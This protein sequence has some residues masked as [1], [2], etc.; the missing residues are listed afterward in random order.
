MHEFLHSF[1][2]ISLLGFLWSSFG[3]FFGFFLSGMLH[4]EFLRVSTM[5]SPENL[6]WVLL[7]IPRSSSTNYFGDA[8]EFI[9]DLL[10]SFSRN[11][12]GVSLKKI[13]WRSSKIFFSISNGISLEFFMKF[14]RS[15]SGNSFRFPSKILLE[16]YRK[17]L[18]ISF[19]APLGL[20][21][22]LRQKFFRVPL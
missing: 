21:P 9:R 11:V 17:L 22:E 1:S 14:L 6:L 19:I 15:S 13:L 16:L 12:S 4:Q 18:P 20:F 2:R 8:P 3:N 5:D 10:H 7:E